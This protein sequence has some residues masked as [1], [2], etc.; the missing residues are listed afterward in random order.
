M[1][2]RFFMKNLRWMANI[3]SQDH[4]VDNLTV[5]E[6]DDA[7]GIT[8]IV[9]TFVSRPLKVISGLFY[10]RAKAA[11][12]MMPF[13]FYP[14]P[15]SILVSLY[16]RR[17]NRWCNMF[18]F[19]LGLISDRLGLLSHSGFYKYIPIVPDSSGNANRGYR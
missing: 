1:F 19:R 6:V 2:Y 5:E 18:D 15:C 9:L 14:M 7:V 17:G 4:L 11:W 10:L 8:G 12:Q 3:G 16:P 13:I